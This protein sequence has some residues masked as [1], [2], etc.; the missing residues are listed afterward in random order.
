MDE[1]TNNIRPSSPRRYTYPTEVLEF[2]TNESGHCIRASVAA[3]LICLEL[4]GWNGVAYTQAERDVF[5][6]Q[7][8]TTP[9][10]ENVVLLLEEHEYAN[11]TP[12][13][14]LA[15]AIS[16]IEKALVDSIQTKNLDTVAMRCDLAGKVDVHETWLD[17]DSVEVWCEQRGFE[18]SDALARYD[19]A[20]G[21]LIAE[22]WEY[23][24][25]VRNRYENA[26]ALIRINGFEKS[27]QLY[28]EK[29]FELL[30]E[31][32]KKR[33]TERRPSVEDSPLG[34]RER[35]VLLTI[36]A[37]LCAELKFDT[38]KTSKT[39]NAIAT[40]AASRGYKVSESAIENHLNRIPNALE[41]R[42]T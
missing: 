34:T 29:Y 24:Q 41:S 3:R 11:V 8:I 39:A 20:E 38:E 30:G 23:A 42:A 36:I 14:T 18:V 7:H 10:G 16:A 13:G 1:A 26:I 37:T 17:T 9:D 22:T 15:K 28:R 25:G 5:G 31:V 4:D 40:A 27:D 19:R 32:W 2:P 21:V 35:N 12:F 6:D 33:R